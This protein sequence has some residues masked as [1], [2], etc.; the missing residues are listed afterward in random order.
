[1]KYSILLLTA[2]LFSSIGFAGTKCHWKKVRGSY[3]VQYDSNLV[4]P[5]SVED[6]FYSIKKPV[7]LLEPFEDGNEFQG[8]VFISDTQTSEIVESCETETVQGLNPD[9][10]FDRNRAQNFIDDVTASGDI[11][12]DTTTNSQKW[13]NYFNSKIRISCQ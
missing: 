12:G 8:T 4:N 5:Q 10:E 11:T 7:V 9:D 6:C 3:W 2:S 13:Q 1:M